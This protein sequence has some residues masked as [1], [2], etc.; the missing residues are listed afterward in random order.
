[1]GTTTVATTLLLVASGLLASAQS[2]FS[3]FVYPVP[4]GDSETYHSM[5]TVMVEY[6]SNFETVAIWTFCASGAI[7]TKFI[8]AAP[9]FNATVPIFLNFT[10]PRPC[11]FNIRSAAGDKFGANS[12]TFNVI[13]EERKGGR[14]AFGAGNPPSKQS[15]SPP[16]LSSSP[17]QTQTSTVLT[18]TTASASVSSSTQPSVSQTADDANSGANKTNESVSTA[19]TAPATGIVQSNSSETPSPGLSVGAS[20]GIAVGATVVVLASGFV[21]FCWFWRHKKRR[22]EKL[23]A[24]GQQPPPRPYGHGDVY[25]K[26]EAPPNYTSLGPAGHHHSYQHQQYHQHQFGGELGTENSPREMGDPWPV[27]GYGQRTHEMAA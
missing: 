19:T 17:T 1:M 18:S 6:I 22:G 4:D 21:G 8:Q 9:S 23:P 11:W 3:E 10:S 25:A 16:V 20:V 12:Q 14:R 13:G 5:D 24:K 27:N 2:D 26:M 15:S 7:E